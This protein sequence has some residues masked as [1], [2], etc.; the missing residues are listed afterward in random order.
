MKLDLEDQFINPEDIEPT[1]RQLIH[2][3]FFSSGNFTVSAQW[4]NSNPFT[5]PENKVT[6]C[7]ITFELLAFPVL[8]TSGVDVIS[9]FNE[10]TSQ[11][12][13]LYVIN[14]DPLPKPA[15]KPTGNETA[16]YWRCRSVTP[17]KRIRDTYATIWRMATIKGHI[18]AENIAI[19]SSVAEELVVRLY[20]DKRLLKPGESPIMV[21][22]RNTQD[23]GAD[24]LRTGQVTV[25]AT[26]GI[27]RHRSPDGTPIT[28][29][30][31]TR[32]ESL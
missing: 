4:R 25:E 20:T 11:I 9:R 2:G 8:T 5:E 13:N 16:V 26:Y 30:K 23:D 6:G 32:K 7:T 12:E 21:D 18:F 29:L 15:W 31:V 19:S 1:L 22:D 28:N 27:I 17:A 10:W 3:Y 14:H 24:P